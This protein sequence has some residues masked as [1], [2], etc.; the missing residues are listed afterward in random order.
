MENLILAACIPQ[1]SADRALSL[2]SQ[3]AMPPLALVKIGQ[4]L[5][6][7]YVPAHAAPLVRMIAA[8]AMAGAAGQRTIDNYS[9]GHMPIDKEG[10]ILSSQVAPW[11]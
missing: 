4:H 10:A 7:I 5:N 6:A 9:G 1:H 2:L 3:I 11:T 8:I